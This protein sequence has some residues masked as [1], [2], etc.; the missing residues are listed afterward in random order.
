MNKPGNTRTDLFVVVGMPR[1]A[2]TFLYHNLQRHPEIFLPARKEVN[3][4]NIHH[5]SGVEWYRDQYLEAGP[6]QVKGDISPPCFM[7]P[8]SPRRILEHDRDARAILVVRDPVEWALSFY[9]QFSSFNFVMPSFAEYLDGYRYEMT[10]GSLDVRFREGAI[11]EGIENFRRAFGDQLLIYDYSHFEHDRLDVLRAIESFLGVDPWFAPGNFDDMRINASS[12]RNAKAVSWLLS[13]EWFIRA[14]QRSVP[15]DVIKSVRSRFD[16]FNAGNHPGKYV[17]PENH[18]ALAEEALADQ[19][20]AIAALFASGPIV[21]GDGAPFSA[22][23]RAAFAEA[24][25]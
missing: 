11:V 21:L 23:T 15:T 6:H 20:D 22:T 4:F 7:D 3:Y 1:G 2:T 13:R 10:E 19:R 24:G 17:H 14:V 8:D 25:A 16:R 5:G 9:A 12:R 18:V